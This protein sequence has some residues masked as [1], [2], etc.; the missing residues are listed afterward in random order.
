LREFFEQGDA[1]RFL[2]R[3]ARFHQQAAE[4]HLH[5]RRLHVLGRIGDRTL[6]PMDGAGR[7]A[8]DRVAT[9]EQH[10]QHQHRIGVTKLGRLAQRLLGLGALD[11]LRCI[12]VAAVIGFVQVVDFEQRVRVVLFAQL[13]PYPDRFLALPVGG[14]RAPAGV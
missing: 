14:Q 13:T 2:G 1:A 5:V 6:R 3:I 11:Q 10:R 4:Q 12:H 8:L 7:I 9:V